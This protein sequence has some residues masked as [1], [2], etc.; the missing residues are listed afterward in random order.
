MNKWQHIAVVVS[1]R[2]TETDDAGWTHKLPSSVKFYIDGEPAGWKETL[3]AQPQKDQIHILNGTDYKLSKPSA[4][5]FGRFGTC[6]CMMYKGF[7]DEVRMWHASL[8]GETIKSF[9]D[10]GLVNVHPNL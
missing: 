5:Y 3:P 10:L 9:K 7:L 8:A 1:I 6:Q 2:P 4:M